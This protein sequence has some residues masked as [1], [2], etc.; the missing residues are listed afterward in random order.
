MTGRGPRNY[1][2]KP[3]WEA[4]HVCVDDTI[5]LAYVEILPN[6]TGAVSVGFL[7]R[8]IAWFTERGMTV[9]RV[10]TD[11]GSPNRSGAWAAWCADPDVRHLRTRPYRPRSNGNA[12]RFIQTM[13]R[14]WAYAATYQSSDGTLRHIVLTG[15]LARRQ[16]WFPQARRNAL[17]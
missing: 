4:V 11:N 13:L 17:P 14:E 15:S 7:E 10:M 16:Q 3:G 5:R 12:E 9:E 6:E 2:N 1:N 8:A